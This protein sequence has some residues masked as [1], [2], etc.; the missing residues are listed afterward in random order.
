MDDCDAAPI[1][2]INDC[3]RERTYAD[4]DDVLVLAPFPGNREC[5]RDLEP[6]ALA[7]ITFTFTL[8]SEDRYDRADDD[9]TG[10]DIVPEEAALD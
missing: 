9:G 5:D 8:P 4:A 3:A 10:L 7:P 1:P 2:C 6:A